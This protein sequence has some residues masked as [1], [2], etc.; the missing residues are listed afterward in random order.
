VDAPG[1][2]LGHCERHTLLHMAKKDRNHRVKY[3]GLPIT[4]GGHKKL[5]PV[6]T[7]A[8]ELNLTALTG[9]SSQF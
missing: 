5:R 8:T 2:R 1:P 4:M 7:A 9:R 3:N 6:N